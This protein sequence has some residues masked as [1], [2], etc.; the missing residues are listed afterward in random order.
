MR[1]PQEDIDFFVAHAWPG[2]E[3]ELGEPEVADPVRCY[4]SGH[5]IPGLSLREGASVDVQAPRLLAAH[6]SFV[7]PGLACVRIAVEY[8]F[9]W[10]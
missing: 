6:Y 9:L 4:V 1:R 5:S 10:L 7:T 3:V 2:E 8:D